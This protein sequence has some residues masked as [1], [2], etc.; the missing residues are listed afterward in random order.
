MPPTP[1][2]SFKNITDA[3]NG[4]AKIAADDDASDSPNTAD[5]DYDLLEY[6]I[7]LCSLVNF[8]H[9]IDAVYGDSASPDDAVSSESLI[10]YKRKHKIDSR[11]MIKN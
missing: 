6:K 10:Y 3:P 11:S 9:S 7:Y 5:N 2:K 8:N 4:D 1:K